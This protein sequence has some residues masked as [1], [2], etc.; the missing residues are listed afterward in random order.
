MTTLELADRTHNFDIKI[1]LLSLE[2][3]TLGPF[4][5]VY[6]TRY[7][8]RTCSERTTVEHNSK[9]PATEGV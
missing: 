3:A 5:G 7:L 6:F 9:N 8:W 4:V 1:T 2:K